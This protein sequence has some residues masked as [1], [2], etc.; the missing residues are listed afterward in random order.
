MNTYHKGLSILDPRRVPSLERNNYHSIR[1][2]LEEPCL[3]DNSSFMKHLTLYKNSLQLFGNTPVIPAFR[4]LR[5]EG[6]HESKTSLDNM[7]EAL[8]QK[9]IKHTVVARA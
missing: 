4:R 2:K 8:S 5:M 9:Q 7:D 6:N 1:K 3:G